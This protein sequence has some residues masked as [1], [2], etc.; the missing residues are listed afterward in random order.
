[1][2]LVEQEDLDLLSKISKAVQGLPEINLGLKNNGEQV[3]LSCHILARACLEIF[4]VFGIVL[5]DG[6]FYPNAEH[7][8][9]ETKNENVIDVCP[10]GILTQNLN[11]EPLLIHKVIKKGLYIP[12]VEGMDKFDA[13]TGNCI[14]GQTTFEKTNGFKEAW[15]K[16]SVETITTILKKQST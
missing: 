4:N 7:S 12:N 2:S 13:R 3:L 15:F 1:V 10:V 6:C 16:K 9:L 5:C 14:W 11:I 8:W